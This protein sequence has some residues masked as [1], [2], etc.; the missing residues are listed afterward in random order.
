MG[1]RTSSIRLI[2]IAFFG[3]L[4]V[5]SGCR[6]TT[7]SSEA[8]TVNTPEVSLTEAASDSYRLTLQADVIATAAQLPLA[9][10][11]TLDTDSVS[12]T[13]ELTPIPGD[14]LASRTGPCPQPEGLVVQHRLGFC[15]STPEDWDIANVDG[16]LAATLN[17]TPGQ[18]ISI[19]PDST[20]SPGVCN[21][22]I[23]I[24]AEMSPQ[25]HLET[26]HAEFEDQAATTSLSAIAVRP[27]GSL[28]LPGFTWVMG[29]VSGSVYADVVGAGRIAHISFSGTDCP[30]DPLLPVLETL[31]FNSS[32]F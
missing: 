4:V 8:P 15:V 30:V 14:P 6:T 27:L 22:T 17:T 24:A 31:R 11:Q 20:E 29:N 25:G 2:A 1:F 23:Y 9:T 7:E 16:G 5:L 10:F 28:A 3:F 12:A 19:Q 18:A 21:L 32:E 26:R 13:L